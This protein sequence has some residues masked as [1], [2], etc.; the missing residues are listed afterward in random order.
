LQNLVAGYE[1]KCRYADYFKGFGLQ[2][3]FYSKS[4]VISKLD[5]PSVGLLP[6]K[7]KNPILR[8]G[9]ADEQ[10]VKIIDDLS[11]QLIK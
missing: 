3:N 11:Y 10:S 8:S 7:E 1:G 6:G 5:K 4:H 9:M 2:T